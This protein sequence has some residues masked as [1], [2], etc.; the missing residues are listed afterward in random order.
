[1]THTHTHTPR[2]TGRQR[3]KER[4]RENYIDTAWGSKHSVFSIEHMCSL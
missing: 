4:E 1:L 3:E 2:S